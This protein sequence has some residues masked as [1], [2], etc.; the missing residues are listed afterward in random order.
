MADDDMWA[1]MGLPMG[2][3]KQ[4]V[5]KKVDISARMDKTRREE[6]SRVLL[7]SSI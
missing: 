6:V 7:P 2:F 3:G 1:Q 4:N 5:K